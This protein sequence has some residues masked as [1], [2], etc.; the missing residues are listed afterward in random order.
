MASSDRAQIVIWASEQ[1]LR[2]RIAAALEEAGHDLGG[3]AMSSEGP[4]ETWASCAVVVLSSEADPVA[5]I[6][7]LRSSAGDIPAVMVVSSPEEAAALGAGAV[8]AEG[9]VYDHELEQTL[10]ASLD[11]VLNEQV[12]VPQTMRQSLARPVLSH[13]EKQ[14]LRLVL[15]GHTNGEIAARLY[16]S[17]STVKSH[18]SSS[19]RKLGVSSRAEASR[20]LRE[21]TFRTWS[22]RSA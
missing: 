22:A 20:R 2:Q 14:V 4:A 17:E 15:S 8:R 16:L 12:C 6:S 10:A 3:C 9:V 18:L 13:R 7:A 1:A 11:A 5:R 21:P 19:F